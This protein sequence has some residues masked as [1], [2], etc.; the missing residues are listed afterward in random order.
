[1]SN[2]KMDIHGWNPLF[3]LSFDINLLI[4]NLQIFKVCLPLNVFC[5]N[6]CGH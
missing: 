5:T 2:R 1:M 6:L 4:N 3:F